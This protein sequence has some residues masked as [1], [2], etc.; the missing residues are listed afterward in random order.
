MLVLL[1]YVILLS[2]ISL[3]CDDLNECTDDSCDSETGC[4]NTP[5]G[6]DGWMYLWWMWYG[7]WNMA[8][9]C[10]LWLWCLH[11]WLLLFINCLPIFNTKKLSV[12]IC[13]DTSACSTANCDPAVGCSTSSISCDY[14]AYTSDGWPPLTV[15]ITMPVLLISVLLTSVFI[16]NFMFANTKM[17]VTPLRVMLPMVVW[18]CRLWWYNVCTTDS[19]RMVPWGK[20][21]VH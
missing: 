18:Y 3:W 13:I 9:W 7:Y 8:Y 1:I 4:L 2:T 17:H 15:T 6:Y 5:I 11:Y 21:I 10:Y 20:V 16:M 19:C 14:D 12:M